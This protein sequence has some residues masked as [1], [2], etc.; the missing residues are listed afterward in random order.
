MT[1]ERGCTPHEA[2]TAAKLARALGQKWG[3]VEPRPRAEYRPDFDDRFKR[4]E[5]RAAAR[6]S[7]EY[8]RCGKKRCHCARAA[9]PSHG[10]Y[11]YGKRR[12]GRKVVSVY[13]GR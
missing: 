11:K 3:F 2:A 9:S 1:V 8:R 5:S 6:W 13:Y 12:D 7:W 10:P 4:A